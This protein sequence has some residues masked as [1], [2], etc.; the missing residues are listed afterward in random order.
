[1]NRYNL[2]KDSG[3]S[4]LGNIPSNWDVTRNKYFTIPIQDKSETGTEELLSVSEKK[5]VI[6][7]RSIRNEEEHLSTSKTLVGY[8]KVL[9]GDLVSNIMLMWKRGLGVSNFKGI[10]SPSYS[11]FRFIDSEP[12]YYHYLFRTDQYVSEFRRNSTGVI[13]SRLRL[14]DDSFGLIS[15]HR[16]PLS[17]QK[18]I[19]TFLDDKTKKIDSLIQQK[20]KKIELLKEKRSSLINHVVTK[21]LDSNVEMKDSGVE[22]IGKIPSHWEITKFKYKGEV[23]IGLSYKPENLVDK[24]EGTLVMRSSNVQNGKPSFNDNVYVDCKISDKLKTRE[25]DILICSRNGSRKLIGKNCLITKDI[26]GMSW[27]VFMTMYRTPNYKYF[28]WL[29]NSPVFKSQSGLFLTS[30]INQLTVSTLE[31]MIVPYV[32][33]ENEQQQIVEYLDKQTEEIDTLIQLE[34]KKIDTLKEYRQSLILNVVTGKIRVC[35]EDDSLSLNSQTI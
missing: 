30:T 10:V 6:P 18:Q 24:G 23:I 35:K 32:N 29:L 1:M 33:D 15:S 28:Y 8:L 34:Q 26:E 19:V 16:P 3:I 12:K 21:G 25:G 31:N 9:P 2:Y 17:E 5:G 13:E 11:V 20:E 4:W 27:G 14:Y 7:R 22:W